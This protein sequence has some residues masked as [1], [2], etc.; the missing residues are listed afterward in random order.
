[1]SVNDQARGPDQRYAAREFVPPK[2]KLLIQLAWS[3]EI[4]GVLLGFL[5]ASYLTFGDQYPTDLFGWLLMAPLAAVACAELFRIPLM[6]KVRWGA[7]AATRSAALLGVL[8]LSYVTFENY[9]LGVERIVT[10]RMESVEKA[11]DAV[12]QA[13]AEYRNTQKTAERQREFNDRRVKE[14]DEREASLRETIKETEQQLAAL[15]V[16]ETASTANLNATLKE[17][18]EACKNIP[19]ECYRPRTE[20]LLKAYQEKLA[21]NGL[22]RTAIERRKMQA[23]QDLN[24]LAGVDSATSEQAAE[25]EIALAGNNVETARKAFDHEKSSNVIH[26]IAAMIFGPHEQIAPEQ[27]LR[28]RGFFSIAIAGTLMLGSALASFSYY[29]HGKQSLWSRFWAWRAA[30]RLSPAQRAVARGQLYSRL[31]SVVGIPIGLLLRS[32]RAAIARRRKDIVRVVEKKIEIPV[33]RVVEKIVERKV[34]VPVEKIVERKVEVPV[35]VIKVAKT[36]VPVVVEKVVVRDVPEQVIE[37][38]ILVEKQHTVFVPYTGDG[39][40]PPPETSSKQIEGRPA[41]EALASARARNAA[42]LRALAPVGE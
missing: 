38:P 2:R 27:V 25:K 18:W 36:E 21:A 29:G 19:G 37:K 23:E 15:A 13:E 39:P 24:N 12:T 42:N 9:S 10:K 3:V 4:V 32:L 31:A 34:E 33:D 26:R 30:V 41:Q 14:R 17:T 1:M 16:Q 5:V 6:E 7:G 28:V 22:T 20:P 11:R 35:D 40:L 8:L